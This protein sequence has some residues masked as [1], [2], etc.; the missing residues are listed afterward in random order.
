MQLKYLLVF[1]LGS[2]QI[3]QV[4]NSNDKYALWD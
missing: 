2:V 3:A 1:L 4:S